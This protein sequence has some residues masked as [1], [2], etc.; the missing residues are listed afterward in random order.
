MAKMW[1]D[2]ACRSLGLKAKEIRSEQLGRL[3]G[4]LSA[5]VKVFVRDPHAQRVCLAELERFIG[6][7][8]RAVSS[9]APTVLL[10]ATETDVVVAR[11][12]ARK[13]CDQVGF[14]ETEQVRVA[15]VV[16]EL[17]RNMVMYAGGGKLTLTAL[18]EDRPGVRV[19]AE[20]QGQG[21]PD[22]ASV[23]AGRHRSKTGMGMGLIGS[24]RLMDQLDIHT[25]PGAG[26]RV[27]AIRYRR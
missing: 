17:A 19:V 7:A 24:K 16:S 9:P 22:L 5:S 25:A 27:T 4:Q 6:P 26:T 10:V 11:G 3:V 2:A 15:T 20:D 14:S 23:L 18:S 1:L 13:L 21:I 12:H 8:V